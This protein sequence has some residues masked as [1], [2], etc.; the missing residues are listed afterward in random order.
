MYDLKWRENAAL[1]KWV[2]LASSLFVS[3]LFI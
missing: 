3:A 2:V 1:E